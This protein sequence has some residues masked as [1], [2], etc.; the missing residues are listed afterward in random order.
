MF[1]HFVFVELGALRSRPTPPF[2]QNSS[3]GDGRA[4]RADVQKY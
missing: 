4:P 2:G 1:L 3:I